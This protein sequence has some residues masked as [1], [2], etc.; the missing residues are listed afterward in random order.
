MITVSDAAICKIEAIS[1]PAVGFGTYLLTE[2][3]AFLAVQQAG[4]LG[5][6]IF[7]TATFYRNFG[8]VGRAI[9]EMGRE[10]AYIISKVWPDA[11]TKNLLKKDLETTLREL[12]IAQLDAY[13]IHWPNH[14]VPIE[15]TLGTMDTLRR[16][17]KVRHL[18]FSNVTVAHLTRATECGIPFSWVQVEMHPHFCDFALLEWCHERKIG[19]QAW[20]PLGRGQLSVDPE[21]MAIGQK[22]GKTASQVA[23]RWIVQ[24]GC[25]PLPC[26][27]NPVHMAANFS[28]VDWALSPQ[29]MQQLNRQAKQGNRTRISLERG[30]GFTDEFDFTYPECWPKDEYIHLNN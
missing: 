9:R 3:E 1:Y 4:E 12:G 22:Y 20:A 27:R 2:E 18:G 11:Q 28:V 29:D 30:L 21:L 8:P 15:E 16:E 13:L 7:D 14:Q 23:L 26:S 25:V 19:V 5:Y 10:K 6:R 24:N 17:G